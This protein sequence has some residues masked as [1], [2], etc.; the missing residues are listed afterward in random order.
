MRWTIALCLVGVLLL[1]L[2]SGGRQ[3][4]SSSDPERVLILSP[5]AKTGPLAAERNIPETAPGPDTQAPVVGDVSPRKRVLQRY[6]ALLSY[7][8]ERGVVEY[9]ERECGNPRS[10]WLARNHAGLPKQ[11]PELARLSW[12]LCR[13]VWRDGESFLAYLDLLRE[14]SDPMDRALG[15]LYCGDVCVGYAHF[16]PSLKD[17]TPEE[18]PY[19][20]AFFETRLQEELA[21]EGGHE[22]DLQIRRLI[23][24]GIVN[25]VSIV[26][27]DLTNP[28]RRL[29]L[30]EG[31][32]RALWEWFGT[33]PDPNVMGC[34]AN[35]LNWYHADYAWLR[36]G[37][38]ETC[39]NPAETAE[40]R[41][42]ALAG[43]ASSRITEPGMIDLAEE[44]IR[45][46][47]P[48]LQATAFKMFPFAENRNLL[49][50]EGRRFFDAARNLIETPLPQ[51]VPRDA[52]S[53][54]RQ[55]AEVVA[56]FAH[57]RSPGIIL[58]YLSNPREPAEDRTAVVRNLQFGL[59][60]GTSDVGGL[61]AQPLTQ[62][63][64]DNVAANTSLPGELRSA[65][66]ESAATGLIALA[67]GSPGLA[68]AELYRIR[69]I[70]SA[71]SD[72]QVRA[73][74]DRIWQEAQNVLGERSSSTPEGGK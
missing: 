69:A 58:A 10:L 14:Q 17:P 50:P 27:K 57:P 41:R 68:L 56:D 8:R 51:D 40:R 39:R 45:S 23:A 26:S 64:L 43:F 67:R 16:D 63:L 66:V 7:I 13:E 2:V 44:M 61:K 53:V 59:G 71:D 28:K 21:S 55:A 70:A 25:Q 6:Q 47:N 38:I 19:L 37:L 33:E 46:G 3:E 9:F 52:F 34:L 24:R 4:H 60:W 1:A 48:A 31:G 73:S 35:T 22:R 11:F 32:V 29:P 62:M 18:G 74:W 72:P 54:R 42:N 65:A 12:A 30:S 20:R 49:L 15:A 5:P 36:D